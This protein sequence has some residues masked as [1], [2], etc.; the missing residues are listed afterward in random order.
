ML[1]GTDLAYK[2]LDWNC[3][4][5]MSWMDV[6]HAV[7]QGQPHVGERRN[8]DMRM[9]YVDRASSVLLTALKNVTGPSEVRGSHPYT[10]ILCSPG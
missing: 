8:W 1:A 6:G 3:P 7:Q 9:H 5:F 2:D 4:G 10:V